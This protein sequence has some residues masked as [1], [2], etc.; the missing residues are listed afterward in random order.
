M[1]TEQGSVSGLGTVHGIFEPPLSNLLKA[2]VSRSFGSRCPPA[3]ARSGRPTTIT[4]RT[5]LSLLL[6]WVLYF[7]QNAFI[8]RLEHRF[9]ENQVNFSDEV[10]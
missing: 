7:A 2:R 4:P 1:G 6:I 9:G 3:D 8:A 5:G 10:T